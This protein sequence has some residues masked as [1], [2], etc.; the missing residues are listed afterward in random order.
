MVFF[1]FN[2]ARLSARAQEILAEISASAGY[3]NP[4]VIQIEGHDDASQTTER[5]QTISQRR[6]DAV[7]EA[8]VRL[9][10]PLDRMRIAA[11]G[12]TRLLVPT[13]DGVRE[14]QNRRVEI[15]LRLQAD[16]R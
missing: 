14:P 15:T 6:A 4:A 7:A 3:H 8:L 10:W 9:G 2:D 16:A 1:D 5:A 12:K 11:F 13:P